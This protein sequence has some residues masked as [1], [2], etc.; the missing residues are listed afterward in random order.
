MLTQ[1]QR[2]LLASDYPRA[3]RMLLKKHKLGLY[4]EGGFGALII[5]VTVANYS[6]VI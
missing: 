5:S 3:G 2:P 1:S 6:G 4:S